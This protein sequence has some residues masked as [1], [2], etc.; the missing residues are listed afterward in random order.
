[1]TLPEYDPYAV[2]E[3]RDIKRGDTV[4]H[5]DGRIGEVMLLGRRPNTC[6]VRWQGGQVAWA[7]FASL[8]KVDD[9]RDGHR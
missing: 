5:D 7:S 6:L 2:Y 1:M 3:S 4:K 8:E 9:T